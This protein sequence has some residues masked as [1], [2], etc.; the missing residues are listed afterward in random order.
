M[1]VIEKPLVKAT[2]AE[3]CNLTLN[4]G[5][6]VK[7]SS[8]EDDHLNQ[9]A[10]ELSSRG[11]EMETSIAQDQGKAKTADLVDADSERDALIASLKLFLRAHMKW[12]REK[13]SKDASILYKIIKKHGLSMA[14]EN[15]EEESALLDSLLAELAKPENVQI[16]EKLNLSE[17]IADLNAAEDYFKNL[18]LEAIKIEATKEAYI[19]A[20]VLKKE[21][22]VLQKQMVD[23]LNAM[24]QANPEKYA[25][26]SN[27]I[28][29]L[30]KIM[31]QKIR[32]RTARKKKD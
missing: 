11:K 7:E 17:L 13:L 23:Y 21:L 20:T 26:V 2:V 19:A 4:M 24:Q 29:E 22:L 31:N 27:K 10:D 16:L 3:S 1:S 25:A 32:N 6:A 18:Y 9:K 5:E 12:K 30:I 15:Y 28:A 8:V 14:R